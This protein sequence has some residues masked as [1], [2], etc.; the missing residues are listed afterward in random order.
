[1]DTIINNRAFI[2]NMKKLLILLIL[3]GFSSC[4]AKKKVVQREIKTQKNDIILVETEEI[5]TDTDFSKIIE[6]IN[7]VGSTGCPV[8]GSLWSREL[9]IFSSF[10]PVNNL[11]SK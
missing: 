8:I 1:M 7:F 3:V 6:Q 11:A 9:L 10:K 5:K 2:C 4:G